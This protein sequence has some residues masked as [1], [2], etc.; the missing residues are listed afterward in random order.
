MIGKLRGVVDGLEDDSILL[1]VSG[2][3]YI[4][5]CTADVIA[6]AVVGKELQVYTEMIVRE[7]QMSLY[8]FLS[9]SEKRCF[10]LLQTVQGVG[11]KMALAILGLM[12]PS[13]LS[14]ALL[15][16][17]IQAFRQVSGVGPKLAGRIVNELKGKEEVAIFTGNIS[18]APAIASTKPS[19]AAGDAVR[20]DVQDALSALAN[21]GFMRSDAFRVVQQLKS[22]NDEMPLEELIKQSLV[23][24]SNK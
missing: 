14:R 1:D 3:G 4:V 15:S 22:D 21:F 19:Y 17:D 9:I 23:R 16:E 20:S 13:Q 18:R 6:S 7:D 2:V 24:L 10:R 5:Y 12:D 11:A 8:G